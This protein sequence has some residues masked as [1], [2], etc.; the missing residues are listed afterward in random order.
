MAAAR[1]QVGG[2][3][4]S[5]SMSLADAAHAHNA[6]EQSLLKGVVSNAYHKLAVTMFRWLESLQLDG[7]Q[8]HLVR[9]EN[10]DYFATQIGA[11]V[12]NARALRS[13]VAQVYIHLYINS[14]FIFNVL[15][16][17]KGN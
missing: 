17:K 12:K 1:A 14:L 6:V 9:I 5:E 8:K 10:Y 11:R 3:E 15:F 16:L 4:S 7:K 13:Y 2:E